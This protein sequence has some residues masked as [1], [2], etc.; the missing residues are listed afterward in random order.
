MLTGGKESLRT[1]AI[2]VLIFLQCS[3]IDS[4]IL[5]YRISISVKK[6]YALDV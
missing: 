6:A 2:S 3:T 4:S 5:K 1:D